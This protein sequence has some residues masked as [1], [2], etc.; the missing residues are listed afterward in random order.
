MPKRCVELRSGSDT[1]ETFARV[2]KWFKAV[3]KYTLE[4]CAVV[5]GSDN[6]MAVVS[7]LFSVS[8]LIVVFPEPVV[9]STTEI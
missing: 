6:N 9:R 1:S 8:S 2:V 7:K 3:W 5:L 4:K